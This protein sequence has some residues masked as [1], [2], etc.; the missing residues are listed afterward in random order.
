MMT[1]LK[2][3]LKQ[4]LFSVFPS[5]HKTRALLQK[6]ALSKR[7]AFRENQNEYESTVGGTI[8]EATSAD[9]T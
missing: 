6:S 8:A 1:K 2:R 4:A 3:R 9:G 5:G 7:C